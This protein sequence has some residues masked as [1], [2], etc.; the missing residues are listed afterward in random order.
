MSPE[1]ALN[2]GWQMSKIVDTD[3][4]PED[5][6]Y[7][8]KIRDT[9]HGLDG[10]IVKVITD[11]VTMITGAI[12]L[13][14][15]LYEKLDNVCWEPIAGFILVA[16]AWLITLNSR[17]RIKL[18]S[19]LLG[20]AVAIAKAIEPK[21]VTAEEERLTVR[22]DDETK[23]PHA[24]VR[25]EALYLR[26]TVGFYIVEILLAIFFLVRIFSVCSV[27]TSGSC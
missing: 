1:R 19:G 7:Y 13:S 23:V 25:G 8:S 24:G 3:V 18:Y 10:V 12:T 5:L 17:G 20:Q 27:C 21:I 22:L 15:L 2:K 14:I 11:S 6:A 26:S 16:I 9:I 4:K